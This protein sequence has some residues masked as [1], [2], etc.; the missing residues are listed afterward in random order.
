MKAPTLLTAA[1]ETALDRALALDPETAGRLAGLEGRVLALE[2]AGLDLTLYLVLGRRI[3]VLGGYEGEPDAAISGTPLAL[4]RMPLEEKGRSLFAGEVRLSGDSEVAHRFQAALEDLDIDWEELLAGAIGDP[5]A[6]Q[7]GRGVRGLGRWLAR[8]TDTL[9]ADLG[10]Y[11]R[12]ESRLLPA[13][14]ELDNLFSDIDR[15][16]SDADRL[17]ARI[18][19]LEERLKTGE[20]GG[21][22]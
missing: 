11:L 7:L 15:I 1:V 4:A 20:G 10:E 18:R 22:C 9:A 16:R 13:R 8:T 6:H 19:R 5:A 2:L 12:E 17:E 21:R 14:I 3:Q